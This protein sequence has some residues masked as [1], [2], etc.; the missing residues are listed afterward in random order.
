[1]RLPSVKRV[2]LFLTRPVLIYHRSVVFRLFIFL[3]SSRKGQFCVYSYFFLSQQGVYFFLNTFKISCR[4]RNPISLF[5]T[6]KRIK[7][8]L[9]WIPC[10]EVKL[11]LK[12][13]LFIQY[14]LRLNLLLLSNN[15]L[16][17]SANVF[18][19]CA[20]ANAK[21]LPTLTSVK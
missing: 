13:S 21:I 6:C 14:L 15:L 3:M 2:D 20:S 1:M 8:A 17:H 5:G 16:G 10:C 19:E 7:E 9:A 4:V 18:T 11:C 12:S